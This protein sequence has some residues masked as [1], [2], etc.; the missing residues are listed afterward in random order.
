M[1]ARNDASSKTTQPD[2][3]TSEAVEAGWEPRQSGFR[4]RLHQLRTSRWTPVVAIS[5]GTLLLGLLI[6][7]SLS[8]GGGA[9]AAGACPEAKPTA[10]ATTRP[11]TSMPPQ[12]GVATASPP[13]SAPE[14]TPKARASGWHKTERGE[15]A[16]SAGEGG[17][18]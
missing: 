14:K 3:G 18:F 7:A 4:Q 9:T 16:V 15:R 2:S 11:E 1:R 6:G 5:A 10:Q 13:Q 12:A 8:G 17:H